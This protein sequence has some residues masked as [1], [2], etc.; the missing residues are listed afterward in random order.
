M[1][2]RVIKIG[3]AALSDGV[4][5]D[6]FAHEVARSESPQI[7][8]HGGG[9]E[10][11]ALS[12]RLGVPVSWSGGRRVTS[13][14]ALD[15]ASMVLN[16]RSN[17]RIVAALVTAGADAI[18]LSGEDGGLVTARLAEDGA[19][20]HVGEVVGVR[21]QLLCYLLAQNIVPVV[22]PVSRGPD[23]NALNVNADEVAAAV[24]IA[25]GAR[26]LLFVTD[27]DGVRANGAVRPSLDA[28][29]A[30]DLIARDEAKNG[31]AVKLR[32]ALGALDRGVS[33][34]RIGRPEAVSRPELGTRVCRNVEVLV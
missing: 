4:W 12:E 29:E 23:G 6:A 19:L 16:G 3:G 7:V 9:P 21:A 31:M 8:V 24:A 14:E 30:L 11:T 22:S 33:A 1:G 20:G 15:V 18:G 34:V 5:L 10:I 17:K 2:P 28:A 26:E 27:V 13:A 32:A 25:V